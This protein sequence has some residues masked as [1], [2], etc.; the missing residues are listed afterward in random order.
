M[1]YDK[2]RLA[3]VCK[4]YGVF[5]TGLPATIEGPKLLWALS[6]NETSFGQ[7]VV[8]RHES[9]FCPLQHGRYSKDG[10]Q[11]ALFRDW[12]CL[13]CCSYTPWQLMAVNAIGYTPLELLQDLERSVEAAVGFCSKLFGRPNPPATLDEFA[14]LWNGS[15]VSQQYIDDLKKN[16]TVEMP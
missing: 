15:G 5:I 12:G 10:L 16:Y 9:A 8:A 13:A 14:R 11:G 6:G 3:D 1:K 4:R 2:A 7:N